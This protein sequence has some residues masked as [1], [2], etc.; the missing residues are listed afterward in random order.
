M[1]QMHATES[2]GPTPRP[3]RRP[4]WFHVFGI[5]FVAALLCVAAAGELLSRPAGTKEIGPA[6]AE[7]AATN[8]LLA[9]PLG[10]HV[11]GWL[12]R[13][14]PGAGAILLLHGVRSDRRRM[15]DRARFLRRLGYSVLL[16]DLPAHGESTGDRI[17]FGAHEAAGV[18][19]ALDYL[20][21]ELPAEP[22][23]AIGVSLG[24]AALVLAKPEGRARA[25]VLESMFP[26]IEEAVSDRLT[27]RLGPAGAMLAPLLLWQLPIRAGVSPSQLRP[28][29][30]MTR[31]GA[32]VFIISGAIDRSTTESETRRIFST[33][34]DPKALW[35]VSGAGHIDLHQFAPAAYEEKVGAFLA[36]ALHPEIGG[37]GAMTGEVRPG[38]RR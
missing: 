4:R 36:R 8:V 3:R 21:R 22:I 35:I 5:G 26:T 37:N 7:L 16:I 15:I 38:P 27:A 25:V 24:A 12:S 11:F 28:I 34:A 23:G 20:H 31:I 1:S 9:S 6:P 18:D 32:P 2:A 14:S 13:G 10:G 29:G 19:A 30:Q 17:T 33:A